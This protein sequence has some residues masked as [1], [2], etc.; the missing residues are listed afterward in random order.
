[1]RMPALIRSVDLCFSLSCWGAQ[2]GGVPAFPTGNQLCAGHAIFSD[3]NQPQPAPE[4]EGNRL[5]GAPAAD[6]YGLV[7]SGLLSSFPASV[8][9]C[10][11]VGF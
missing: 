3:T 10:L 9:G 6:K 2:G 1:M 8:W 11:R 4:S 5:A 7:Q